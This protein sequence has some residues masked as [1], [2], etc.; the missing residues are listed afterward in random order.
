MQQIIKETKIRYINYTE[1]PPYPT[2]EKSN[3]KEL[4]LENNIIITNPKVYHNSVLILQKEDSQFIKLATSTN[5]IEIV[6]DELFILKLA[7]NLIL[8]TKQFCYMNDQIGINIDIA[9]GSYDVDLISGELTPSILL[10]DI[11]IEYILVKG[12]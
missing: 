4:L 10:K 6:S 1:F 7:S 2:Y 9:N 8:K 5:Y 11:K 12:I 3:T